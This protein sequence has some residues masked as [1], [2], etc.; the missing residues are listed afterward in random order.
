MLV[1][2]TVQMTNLQEL[3]VDDTKVSLSQFPKIFE[4]CQSLVKLNFT[5]NERSLTNEEL[6]EKASLD[7]LKKGFSKLTHL[8]V[9]NFIKVKEGDCNN[10]PWLR[11]LQVLKYKILLINL[12]Y[13]F[14]HLKN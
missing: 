14:H 12:Q 9:F 6:I 4:A 13:T 2:S 5:L 11:P 10:E 7:L 3:C 1:Q 8:K